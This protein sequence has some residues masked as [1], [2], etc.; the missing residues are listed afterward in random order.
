MPA[1]GITRL[2]NVP[3]LDCI[4]IPVVMC[5]RPNSR[6]LAV[7]QG[8]GLTLAAAKAS[9][10]MESVE[11]YHAEHI[12]LP[13]KLGSY[14]D[15]AYSHRLVDVQGLPRMR[16]SRF[17]PDLPMLW[18]EGHDLIQDEP[19]W[20]P[21]EMV[22][23]NFT[24]PSPPGAGSF[25]SSSNGLASGN[26]LLEAIN[27]GISE[28]VERDATTLWNLQSAEAQQA[29]RVDLDTVDDPG[30]RSV[31]EKFERA[32]VDVA[33][34]EMTSDV[35]LPTFSCQITDR[36]GD[37]LRA[38]H[39]AAGAGCHPSWHIAMLRALTE[40]AQDRLTLIA[41]SRDDV[42][43]EDYIRQR[44]PDV[45]RN[46]RALLRATGPMR[47]FQA[48]PTADHETFE[49]DLSWMLSR[50][51]AVGIQRA[52]MVDLTRPEFGVPVARMVIPGLEA[53][54][55]SAEDILGPRLD[56]DARELN[57]FDPFAERLTDAALFRAETPAGKA[58]ASSVKPVILRPG[59]SMCSV[60]GNPT[61]SRVPGHAWPYAERL[62]LSAL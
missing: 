61:I 47:P 10:L 40:A 23:L 55:V 57:L 52:V 19:V 16:G 12:T 34:W 41:G 51:R 29:S 5:C 24:E 56:Q 53:L 17:H 1:F 49:E 2:A 62:E 21:Y 7:S 33:V 59:D 32:N 45:L 15:L 18:V 31:L 26:H 28:V 60:T 25:F 37:D 42:L 9:A 8:K 35:G 54:R 43:R 11:S 39:S 44:S 3:G 36:S 58:L 46:E 50:L 38:L 27:H 20:V 4:G 6:S 48:A 13:M 30:C 14:H 22:H